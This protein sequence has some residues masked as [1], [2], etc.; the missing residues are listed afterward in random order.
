MIKSPFKRVARKPIWFYV[1]R[2]TDKKKHIKL[3]TYINPI[4]IL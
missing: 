2:Q 4:L 3:I 1:R